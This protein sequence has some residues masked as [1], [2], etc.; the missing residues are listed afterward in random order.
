[1]R[2]RGRVAR[3]RAGHGAHGAPAATLAVL[4]LLAAL[5]P[6]RLVRANS[7]Q[8][9]TFS[10]ERQE[11]DDESILD[12]LLAQHPLAWR[13]EW[14]RATM[15]LR[16]SQGCLT[17]GQWIDLTQ[18]KLETAMG[19]KATFG[20]ELDQRYDNIMQYSDLSLSFRFPI[21][22]G[23][24]R[25]DFHPSYDK[26]KQDFAVGWDTGPD[27]SSFHLDVTFMIED[28]FN[29]L[30]A[31]RQTRVGQQSEPYLRHPY[32]PQFEMISRHD[33]WRADLGARYLTPSEKNINGYN[34]ITTTVLE[35]LWGTYGW[36]ELEAHALGLGWEA[37][38]DNLQAQSTDQPLDY[39]SGNHLDFRRQWSAEGRLSRQ[40]S[41]SW[42]AFARYFYQE[43][44]ELY[45][46]GIG[47]GRFGA[48]DRVYQGE[49]TY[50]FKAPGW[51]LRA[52]GMYDRLGYDRQ[53]VT[54]AESEVRNKE[55]RAYVTLSARFGKVSVEGTEGIELDLEPYPVTWHHDKGFL[56]LQTTF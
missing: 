32:L 26:S 1:M 12:H 22:A 16:T 55:S 25:G 53:G 3:E 37:R 56:K 15:A 48:V 5:G 49:V 10:A 38:T 18:L 40:I 54:L 30:W 44:T 51:T 6:A 21:Y 46:Q 33:R 43:R 11:E 14:E 8:F 39:S 24:L 50:A 31:W 35:T 41:R 29:N 28:M 45:G 47:P 42:S 13:D 4:L 36:A 52:G 2:A 7:E 17:S 34:T 20:L 27:T 23:R 19:K 9:S